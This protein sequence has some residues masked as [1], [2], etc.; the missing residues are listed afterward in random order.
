MWYPLHVHTHLHK[1]IPSI[2]MVVN[3]FFYFIIYVSFTY[4]ISFICQHWYWS[5][6]FFYIRLVI[7][8]HL[9]LYFSLLWICT[10]FHIWTLTGFFLY[11]RV[12]LMAIIFIFFDFFIAISYTCIRLFYFCVFFIK[13]SVFCISFYFAYVISFICSYSY[14]ILYFFVNLQ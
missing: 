14:M 8:G 4:I 13:V 1:K 5:F 10:N 7:I 12:P 9:Y 2:K 11:M 3:G 6:L